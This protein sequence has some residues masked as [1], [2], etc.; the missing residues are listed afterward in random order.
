MVNSTKA[1]LA[2]SRKRIWTA[3]LFTTRFLVLCREP[4][5]SAKGLKLS[6][7]PLPSVH[8]AKTARKSLNRQR[9][10]LPSATWQVLGKVFAE[11]HVSTRQR[12]T[13]V[14]REALLDGSLPSATLAGAWQ[15][16]FCFF[17]KLFAERLH[18]WLSA[19][20][21]Y[22]FFITC[23]DVWILDIRRCNFLQI[24]SNFNHSFHMR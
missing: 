14:S 10:Y 3:R 20:I 11:S 7:K 23:G 12:L 8:S 2:I 22:L 6:A 16:L 18:G 24:F 13:A 17:E 15:R 1:M 5:R 4:K 21:I 19:K 9:Q